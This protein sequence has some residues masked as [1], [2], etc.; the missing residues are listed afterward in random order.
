MAG[1]TGRQKIADHTWQPSSSHVN[2]G[3][4]NGTDHRPQNVMNVICILLVICFWH[5]VVLHC[6]S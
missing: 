3:I 5:F 4:E 2:N 1:D 6:V